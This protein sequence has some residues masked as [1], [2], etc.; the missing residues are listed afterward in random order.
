MSGLTDRK[1]TAMHK[2][3]RHS[4]STVLML[5]CPVLVKMDAK[6]SNSWIFEVMGA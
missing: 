2:T 6:S 4:G 3:N 5:S 1:C